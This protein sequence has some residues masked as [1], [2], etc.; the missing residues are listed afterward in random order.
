MKKNAFPKKLLMIDQTKSQCIIYN[1]ILH[2]RKLYI[3]LN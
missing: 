3:V 1:S 2:L